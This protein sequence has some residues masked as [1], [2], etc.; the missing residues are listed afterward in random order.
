MVELVITEKQLELLNAAVASG[1]EEAEILAHGRHFGGP[2]FKPEPIAFSCS[3]KIARR[4]L[5]V[6][7]QACPDLVPEIHAAMERQ[8]P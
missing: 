8:A 7:Q 6:A 3:L 5:T 1:S 4:L 2:V